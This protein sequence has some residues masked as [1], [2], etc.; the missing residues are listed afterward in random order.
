MEFHFGGLLDR[1]D[2]EGDG[3]FYK[4]NRDKGQKVFFLCE[5]QFQFFQIHQRSYAFSVGLVEINSSFQ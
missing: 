4:G 3:K 5:F 2:T 1:R